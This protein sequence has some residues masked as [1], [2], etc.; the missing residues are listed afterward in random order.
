MTYISGQQDLESYRRQ[1]R[2]WFQD[3]VPADWVQR[4]TGCTEEEFIAFQREWFAKLRA[5][6]LALPHWPKAWGGEDLPIE[7]QAVIYEEIARSNAPRPVLY[8]ISLYH[9]PGTLLHWGTEEQKQRYLPGVLERGEV[10]CQ[11]FSEPNAGSDLASLRTRAERK[12]DKYIINGQKIWSSM[13][14]TADYCLLLARTDRD[15]PKHKGISYFLMDMK[16][17]G[18]TIRQIQQAS[19][20]AEFCELFLDNVE[21][22]AENLVGAEN[23]GWA[24]AQSTLSSERGLPIVELTERM[25]GYYP[26]LVELARQT[27]KISDP[28]VRRQL[29]DVHA[30]LEA[31]SLFVNSML[32]K[33]VAGENPTEEPSY[34]KIHYSELLRRFTDL[35]VRLQGLESQYAH[36][37]LMGGGYETGNWMFDFINS[38]QWTI[39]GGANEVI[40][41][42][43]AERILGLPR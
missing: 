35:G 27:G 4:Q 25:R 7:Y 15:A 5:A 8:F 11:G 37:Y 34:I 26:Q 24:V 41:N 17:P 9:L 33:V 32:A 29:A 42:I 40:R 20:P 36:P 23:N 43:I 31:C 2:Q 1:V 39:A 38:Y 14:Y 18:I 22:P 16:S 12:G 13:A 28:Q 3:N 30:D 19:G 6:G 10:W 21:I